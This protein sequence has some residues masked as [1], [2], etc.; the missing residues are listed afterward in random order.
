MTTPAAVVR[1][2]ISAEIGASAAAL[3]SIGVTALH[4]LGRGGDLLGRKVLVTAASGGVG[5]IA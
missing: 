1:H 2:R 5:M 4:L 3:P